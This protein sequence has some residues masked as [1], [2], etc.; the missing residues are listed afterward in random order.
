MADGD[1]PDSDEWHLGFE[2]GSEHTELAATAELAQPSHDDLSRIRLNRPMFVV[3]A[4]H[5]GWLLVAIY[6]IAS[7]LLELGAR[8][9]TPLEARAALVEFALSRAV[10]AAM[11][12]ASAA[13]ISW[14][15]IAQAA[16]FT[17]F[18]ANDLTARL[19]ASLCGL[20]L[21]A[22]SFA[23]RP[24]LGRAGALALAA[25]LVLSPGVTWF[26]RNGLNTVPAVAFAF[27]SVGIFLT[28]R[29]RANTP[30]ALG[31]G[32]AIGVSLAAGPAGL[33]MFTTI[34]LALIGLGIADAI[35]GD[36]TW[37]RIR[38]W[39]V[40]RRRI[41]IAAASV[42]I[43]I[44][45]LLG[46]SFFSR[47]LPELILGDVRAIFAGPAPGF[48]AGAMYYLPMLGFYEFMIVILALVGA[49]A[50]LGRKVRSSLALWSF[51]WAVIGVVFYLWV[52]GR[53]PEWIVQMIVPAA[54]LACFGIG[55]LHHLPTWNIARYAIAIVA[56]TTLYVQ[57]M[58]N[59]VYP[60]PDSSE[61]PWA[62]HALLFW[63]EPATSIQTP[64]ECAHALE[65]IPPDGAAMLPDGAPVMAWYLRG[66]SRTQDKA[67]ANLI[68]SAAI[69][70]M[71]ASSSD[72]ETYQFGIE[73]S[74]S[75][76]LRSIGARQAA[77]FFFTSRPWNPV[78]LRDVEI[79]VRAEKSRP[80]VIVTPGA[81]PAS[82][83]RSP[84]NA[85]GSGPRHDS[86]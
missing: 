62:R 84:D 40:R 61:P 50:V 71:S 7:R 79:Q 21:I 15:Q 54:M 6:A 27:A 68:A 55:W 10:P 52:P 74:W 34:A 53:R 82:E 48:H 38:V 49:V 57:V 51:F 2:P 77:R 83:T 32:C 23:I 80:T 11:E 70:A 56:V 85:P 67:N 44:W 42:A 17:G 8:P 69:A 81:N 35:S 18:G 5:L 43:V 28:M 19:V 58:V 24:Y 72:Q 13:S 29:H 41:A 3:T 31:L 12:S 60:A 46:T 30:R 39:W 26:S 65:S 78:N 47:S 9:L 63:S 76:D 4:E 73:E 64:G 75:P 25:L 20:L 36:H 1:R 33:A 37:L 22:A 86:K 14:V 45:I 66:L 16:V 59:F